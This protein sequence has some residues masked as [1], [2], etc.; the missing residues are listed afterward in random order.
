MRRLRSAINACIAAV[1]TFSA[2]ICCEAC[3]E[4]RQSTS[5]TG[6]PITIAFEADDNLIVVPVS[7]EGGRRLRFIFDTGA[8]RTN[9][10]MST[11]A[12]LTGND[13]FSD[14]AAIV[15]SNRQS[16]S[17]PLRV[18]LQ[19]WLGSEEPG[20]GVLV[21]A[22]MLA[23]VPHEIPGSKAIGQ[24]FDGVFGAT[25]L[26]RFAVRIDYSRSMLQLNTD[27]PVRTSDETCDIPIEIGV[28]GLPYVGAI[29]A[30]GQASA[31]T[32]VTLLIDTGANIPLLLNP[33]PGRIPIPQRVVQVPLG[34]RLGG[35]LTGDV[36]RVRW[37]RIGSC[38]LSDVI[39][40]FPDENSRV[41]LDGHDGILGAE[42]LRRFEVTLDYPRRRLLLT[43]TSALTEP[44]E[45]DMSGLT[46]LTTLGSGRVHV[47]ERVRTGSP[48]DSSGLT[49][50]DTLVSV[51]GRP[52]NQLSRVAIRRFLAAGHNRVVAVTVRRNGTV[53]RTDVTLKR[54]I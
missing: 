19:M 47:I 22:R 24:V 26:E 41:A 49:V 34:T 4:Q 12:A 45:I 37:V 6:A 36:G 28:N 38:V 20:E 25:Q 40:Q 29:V 44:F 14:N 18:S 53:F 31:G 7:I 43:P 17:L 3:F 23:Q 52:T 32:N 16:M 2:H 15:R 33:S 51:N 5:D 30:I 46:F 39:T 10:I 21:A 9:L 35:S 50:G 48:A 11:S 27:A 13:L 1:L 42:V 54:I 8:G